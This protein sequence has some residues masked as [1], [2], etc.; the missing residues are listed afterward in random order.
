[1]GQGCWA[2]RVAEGGKRCAL[3]VAKGMVG[4]GTGQE[5]GQRGKTY[6]EETALILGLNGFSP[7]ILRIASLWF[8]LKCI[9]DKEH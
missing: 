5:N 6:F 3:G 2:V 7:L 4:L 9:H 1:M 8:K